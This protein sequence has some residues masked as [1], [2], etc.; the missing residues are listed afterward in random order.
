MTRASGLRSVWV[1]VAT[2]AVLMGVW[3]TPAGAKETPDSFGGSCSFHG[4]VRFSPAATNTQQVLSTSYDATGTC[5]GE[6]NGRD[7]SNAPVSLRQAVRR[8]DGS[9]RYANTTEPGRGTLTFAD[10]STVPFTFEFNYVATEGVLHWRGERSGSARGRGSFLTPTTPPNATSKCAAE[11]VTEIPMDVTIVTSSPLVGDA[12]GGGG[13]GD[14]RSGGG[15]Q[16]QRLRLAVRPRRA[17]AG[18]RTRFSFRVA[19][20]NGRAAPGAVVRFAGRRI[21]VGRKGTT[22]VVARFRR[23]GRRS[24]RASKPGFR[25]ARAWVRVARR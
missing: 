16:S 4:L 22:R 11:G 1:T 19:A 3:T 14:Q 13:K 20:A 9:C 2:T 15:R 10:G 7:V 24:A 8:V 6:L 25:G 23:T 18:R 12:K 21:R 17:Q 5:S